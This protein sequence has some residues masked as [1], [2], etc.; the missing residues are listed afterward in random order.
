MLANNNPQLF[1]NVESEVPVGVWFA[2]VNKKVV[3]TGDNAKE[4]YRQAKQKFP[5]EEIFIGRLPPNQVMLL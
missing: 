3:A 1:L 5:E 4:V 2:I